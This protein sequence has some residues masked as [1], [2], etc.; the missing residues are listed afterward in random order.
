MTDCDIFSALISAFT[1]QF[2]CIHKERAYSNQTEKMGLTH[3][4]LWETIIY[5]VI[6]LGLW[7]RKCSGHAPEFLSRWSGGVSDV[8]EC[9]IKDLFAIRF[10]E[11]LQIRNYINAVNCRLIK[12]LS[13]FFLKLNNSNFKII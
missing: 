13:S 9:Q 10:R 5:L 4:R 11:V 8:S 1:S 7:S 12:S 3:V 6:L 2:I